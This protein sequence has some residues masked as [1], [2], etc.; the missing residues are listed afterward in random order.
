MSRM[1]M[2]ILESPHGF[3]QPW[4]SRLHPGTFVNSR[5]LS[6]FRAILSLSQVYFQQNGTQHLLRFHWIV[7]V[8]MFHPL[9]HTDAENPFY[10]KFIEW[11]VKAR[12]EEKGKLVLVILWILGRHPIHCVASS[13]LDST[14][15][16]KK[17][18]GTTNLFLHCWKYDVIFIQKNLRRKL[19]RKVGIWRSLYIS[20]FQKLIW[21]QHWYL[22]MKKLKYSAFYCRRR[23]SNE[24]VLL[25]G[26]DLFVVWIRWSKNY[27]LYFQ[28]WISETH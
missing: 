10:L 27:L 23:N 9:S 4:V 28:I 1:L 12:T 11:C 8:S 2:H 5:V 22:F 3:S 15:E 17:L 21:P 7:I 25:W 13:K 20:Y 18:N 24:N 26:V 16:S 6:V 19:Y 14:L